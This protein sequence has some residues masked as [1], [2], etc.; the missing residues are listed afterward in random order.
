MIEDKKI[1]YIGKLEFKTKKDCVNYTRKIINNLGC[2]KIDREHEYFNFLD[3]LIKNHSEYFEKI[4]SGVDY[5]Y[6]V[7]NALNKKYYQTMIKRLDGLN[8]VFSWVHCCEFKARNINYSLNY[9]M[10]QAIKDDVIKYK[11]D[12]KELI[13]N[14]CNVI[15][16]PYSEYHVDH[17]E[18][19][20]RVIK[21]N[22]LKLNNNISPLLFGKCSET[23]IPIFK[24]E[25]N[26]F[27]NEWVEYHN[28]NSSFQILCKSCNIK[29]H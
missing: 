4:G 8:I 12:Q 5:Y 29:K 18:P 26:I 17:D 28:K 9:A 7:S 23:N 21:D 15:N 10:R 1:Y 6:I 19:P 20:F 22:F 11:Q 24:D 25:D 27:K 14:F 2:C 13:C 16:I 3:N